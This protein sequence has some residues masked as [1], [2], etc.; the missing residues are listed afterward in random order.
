MITN[1]HIKNIG[2]IEDITISFQNG[3]NVITGETR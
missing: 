2:I 1:I 3:F